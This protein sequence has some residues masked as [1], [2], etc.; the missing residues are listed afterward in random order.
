MQCLS[1]MPIENLGKRMQGTDEYVWD[2]FQ[3]SVKM[4]TYLLAFVVAK[5]DFTEAT[6]ANNVRYRIWSDPNLSEQTQ[7][8]LEIGPKILEFFE[9]FFS[10]P[11][12]LPKLDTIAVPDFGAGAMENWGLIVFKDS[13]LLY[14]EGVSSVKSKHLIAH[15]TAHE[16]AHQWFGEK[17]HIK[18]QDIDKT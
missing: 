11:Y 12:P 8:A 4:S 5:F 2:H 14:K 13:F 1:N 7:Y 3:E 18:Q 15:I 17:N 10:I 6:G 9:K 16:L